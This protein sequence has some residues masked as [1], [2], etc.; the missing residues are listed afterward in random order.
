MDEDGKA[1]DATEEELRACEV[2]NE[3]AKWKPPLTV[4]PQA[5]IDAP[6][7]SS[8]STPPSPYGPYGPPYG[9]VDQA[10][11]SVRGRGVGPHIYRMGSLGMPMVGGGEGAWVSAARVPTNM[12][13]HFLDHFNYE[14]CNTCCAEYWMLIHKARG[15][16]LDGKSP[17]N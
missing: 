3:L 17:P 1:P 2:Q 8:R 16:A 13:V 5:E 6:R 14:V 9:V 4:A 10:R 15:M 11:E 12:V 7:R